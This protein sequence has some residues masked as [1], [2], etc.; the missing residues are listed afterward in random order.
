[1]HALCGGYLRRGGLFSFGLA[2]AGFVVLGV[3]VVRAYEALAVTIDIAPYVHTPFRH[4]TLFALSAELIPVP[5][6][7]PPIWLLVVVI[8]KLYGVL[9]NL[10]HNKFIAHRDTTI[11]VLY[12]RRTL[13]HGHA[14]SSS[15]SVLKLSFTLRNVRATR[16]VVLAFRT[17]RNRRVPKTRSRWDRRR[18]R[19][20]HRRRR[21]STSTTETTS[22]AW[23]C[24]AGWSF[25]S[26]RTRW[27]SR[28]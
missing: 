9:L 10:G 16:T 21:C 5:D 28:S 13:V 3:G 27:T 7:A 18:R 26:E 2:I 23:T 24:C 25:W 14:R 6:R 19:A 8:G 15:T 20:R 12:T 11:R 17:S 22:A 1:M 4:G